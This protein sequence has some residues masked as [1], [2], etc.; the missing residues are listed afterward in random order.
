MQ[1]HVANE[2][3]LHGSSASSLVYLD[4]YPVFDTRGQGRGSSLDDLWT[5]KVI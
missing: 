3:W 5:V 1:F 2:T 4:W